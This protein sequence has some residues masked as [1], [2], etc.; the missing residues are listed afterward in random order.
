[1]QNLSKKD[2]KHHCIWCL[3]VLG[4]SGAP[5]G[6]VITQQQWSSWRT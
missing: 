6:N 1:V 4:E 3:T 2:S 5:G